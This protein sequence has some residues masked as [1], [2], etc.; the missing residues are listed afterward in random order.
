MQPIPSEPPKPLDMCATAPG[1]S[2]QT[3]PASV[4]LYT[5]FMDE[6]SGSVAM[7]G[8][9]SIS[10]VHAQEERRKMMIYREKISRCDMKLIK[11]PRN[12][13]ANRSLSSNPELERLYDAAQ[14]A[15]DEA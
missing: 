4:S 1:F 5:K 6:L 3:N 12:N 9:V 8:D 14:E 7:Q 13:K 10:H 2:T 11:Y 15:S